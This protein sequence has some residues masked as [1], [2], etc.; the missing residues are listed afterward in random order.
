M[1]ALSWDSQRQWLF[2][3]SYDNLIIV[4]DIGGKRGTAYELKCLTLN[5]SSYLRYCDSYSR[6]VL[7]SGHTTKVTAMCYAQVARCLFT[8]DDAGRAL[9]W[10][11][12]A[13]REV[14]PAWANSDICQRC[15]QPFFWN[16]KEMW[17]RRVRAM[18]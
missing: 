11:A 10:D 15:D 18:A 5:K 3:G 6:S 2:S 9:C 14:T 1:R 7:R 17:Q 4:W 13:K 8:F 16:V 12:A